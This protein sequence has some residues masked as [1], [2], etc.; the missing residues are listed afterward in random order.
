MEMKDYQEQE[1]FTNLKRYLEAQQSNINILLDEIGIYTCRNDEKRYFDE[2][3]SINCYNADDFI[4]FAYKYN[5]QSKNIQ[6]N[7]EKALKILHSKRSK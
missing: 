3:F 5:T 1:T 6:D 2:T 4:V 7:I